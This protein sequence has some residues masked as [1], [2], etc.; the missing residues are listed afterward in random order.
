M[1]LV[2]YQKLKRYALKLRGN[3]D[4]IDIVHDAYLY[5][6]EKKGKDLFEENNATACAVIKNLSRHDFE[7]KFLYTKNGIRLLRTFEDVDLPIDN[8]IEDDMIVN[9]TK[10]EMKTVIAGR[11]PVTGQAKAVKN[12]IQFLHIFDK[13]VEGYSQK[14]IAESIEVTP[15]YVSWVVIQ[16]RSMICSTL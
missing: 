12:N 8:T 14:E 1:N 15:A 5:W 2:N 13:L 4:H 7:K 11:R 16:I 10:S 9:E 6:L 3:Y